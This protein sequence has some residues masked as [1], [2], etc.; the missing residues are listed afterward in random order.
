MGYR[1][2]CETF[3]VAYFFASSQTFNVT[4]H[5]IAVVQVRQIEINLLQRLQPTTASGT[6]QSLDDRCSGSGTSAMTTTPH[7]NMPT[8]AHTK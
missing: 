5:D 4:H 8:L 7:G 3:V 1:I 6:V 2:V